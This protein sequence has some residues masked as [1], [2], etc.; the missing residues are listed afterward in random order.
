MRLHYFYVASFVFILSVCSSFVT[1]VCMCNPTFIL[2]CMITYYLYRES[3]IFNS[4]LIGLFLN[5]LLPFFTENISSKGK[6]GIMFFHLK[7]FFFFFF[8]G[9]EGFE[10]N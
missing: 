1:K 8:L 4:I 2:H 7:H 10:Y 6:G 3:H 9:G 5:E